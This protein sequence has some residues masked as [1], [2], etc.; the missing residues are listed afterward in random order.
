MPESK[1]QIYKD[2]NDSW[3]FRLRARNNEIIAVGQGYE[4]K[5]NCL[6]G[7]KSIKR[8]GRKA[9]VKNMETGETL[10]KLENIKPVKEDE[11]IIN[12]KWTIY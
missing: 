5:Q 1:F 8:N 12:E 3:R 10:E 11:S 6:K 9:P 4:N 2:E 7:I